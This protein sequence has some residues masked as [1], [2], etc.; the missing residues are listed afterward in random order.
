MPRRT[1][2]NFAYRNSRGRIVGAGE[3]V[4][5]LHFAKPTVLGRGNVVERL[6]QYRSIRA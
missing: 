1:E 5:L 2:I 3:P 6:W 4:D